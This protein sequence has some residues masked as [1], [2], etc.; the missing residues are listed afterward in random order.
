MLSGTPKAGVVTPTFSFLKTVFLRHNLGTTL[1][2]KVYDLVNLEHSVASQRSPVLIGR[3]C[4]HPPPLAATP[5]SLDLPIL[6]VPYKWSHPIWRPLR[7]ASFTLCVCVVLPEPICVAA[8]VSILFLLPDKSSICG[9]VR[10]RVPTC[11][12][13]NTGL[14]P[15]FWLL[16]LMPS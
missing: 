9:H 12:L 10:P 8:G 1:S 14:F 13:T 16:Y 11:Q 7:S 15:C 3:Y 6:D 5:V 2:L 4:P